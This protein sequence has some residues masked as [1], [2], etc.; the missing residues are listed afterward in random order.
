MLKGELQIR[1]LP[2]LIYYL[3]CF[4]YYNSFMFCQKKKKNYHYY[5][6]IVECKFE[7]NGKRDASILIQ[8]MTNKY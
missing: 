6:Y 7:R 5:L 4:V 1:L 8:V 2:K 3:S